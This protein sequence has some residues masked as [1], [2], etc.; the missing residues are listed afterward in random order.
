M[1]RDGSSPTALRHLVD[2][3]ALLAALDVDRDE[4]EW[5]KSFTGFSATDQRRLSSL[6]PTLKAVS[7][8]LVE[9]F[10]DHLH[11]YPETRAI[12][13]RSTRT[14]DQ[15]KTT[16]TEYLLSL[17]NGHYG[18]SY[19]QERARI[20]KI[21]DM[22]DLGPKVYLGAFTIYYEGLIRALADDSLE[23]N[24]ND[25]SA[26]VETLCENLLSVFRLLSLD[27]Q[28]AMDTYIHSYAEQTEQALDRQLE[29]TTRMEVDVGQSLDTLEQSS[30]SVANDASNIES[31][32]TQQTKDMDTITTE[33]SNLSATIEEIAATTDEVCS[34]SRE[35]ATLADDGQASAE[36]A[37]D[38][39]SDMS[40]AA[41]ELASD[42]ESLRDQ[43]ERITSLVEIIDSIADRT[44]LLSLNASIEA[45]RAGD[46]G[47]GF[48][49]VADEV[50][51]LAGSAKEQAEEIDALVEDITDN[52]DAMAES[53]DHTTTQMSHTSA[54][55]ESAMTTLDKI[56]TAVR[57]IDAS[58]AE[59]N[60]AT[61]SQATSSEEVTSMVS[62]LADQ[63]AEVADRISDVASECDDQNEQ[64]RSIRAAVDALT[65]LTDETVHERDS[66]PFATGHS[67]E[68]PVN[69]DVTYVDE[70]FS[71]DS[72]PPHSRTDESS[73]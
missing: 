66:P 57:D 47:R 10:Y 63:A 25:A 28:I 45:A 44:N 38:A 62:E 67:P 16:Q 30:R 24:P 68:T 72:R 37:L 39:M 41:E 53:F 29:L 27:Q 26:A 21:H 59:V 48:A 33:M 49:V 36:T 42:M 22:L 15:L 55:V 18:P 71:L 35:A 2:G 40:V 3:K 19:F 32:A 23:S 69:S 6:D 50:K 12:L 64:V 8:D 20:G 1:T 65:Q 46:A 61:D 54:E 34:T 31:I 14:V 43:T 9:E 70:P 4:I 51:H 7:P 60:D 58:L 73:S 17:S 56:S 13:G 5:R 11:Q 52:S